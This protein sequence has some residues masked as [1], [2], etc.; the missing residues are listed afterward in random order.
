MQVAKKTNAQGKKPKVRVSNQVQIDP[1]NP[2]PIGNDLV[3][4]FA[5][6]TAYLPLL[7]PKDRFAADLLEARLL[8]VTNNACITTKRDYCQGAGFHDSGGTDLDKNILEWFK[9]M[10]RNN[11]GLNKINR[12]IF[13]DF[14]T[15]GNVPIELVR[16][17]VAGK[18]YLNIYVH[19]LM[20]WR[21]A[22]PNEDDICDTAIQSKL[23]LRKG[24]VLDRDTVK[25]SKKLPIYNPMRSERKNWFR[26]E[27][28]AERTL[29]WYKNRVTGFPYYGLPSNV[30]SMISQILEYKGGRFNLDMFE[31]NMVAAA[32][33]ALKGSLSQD[34][35]T[36]IGKDLINT[37]TGDGKR[38]R[39]FVVASE[40]GIEGSDYHK[41]E[42][43]S[44]GSYLKADDNWTQKI[45]L[46]NQWDAVL[47]G[48]ISPSTLGKGAGFITKIYEIK[49]NSVIKPAQRDLMDD[50]WTHIFKIAENWLGLPFS[51]Y[52]MEFKNNI[53]ISGLTDVDITPA[54][55]INEV[56]KAKGLA[57]D[58][59]RNGVY[60][61]AAAPEP[62]KNPKK[63]GEDVPAK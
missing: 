30:A 41:M 11:E 63:G 9:S 23:F 43:E 49:L 4:S 10:N 29:I 39:T 53:D 61:K 46:A 6:Q 26:D 25:K 7:P 45:I 47:A 5:N 1:R 12:N 37:Y 32:I 22:R 59:K 8:S 2:I 27:K 58:P 60:M 40:E 62:G 33:I 54:V 56:R 21:L 51:K 50:V 55:Q 42:T 31:N 34:E 38:G 20:E 35:A 19:N 24:Y 57:E 17:T 18:K 15:Q 52:E 48:I 14:F 36:R 28:G 3:F 44:D 16:Y 13:E